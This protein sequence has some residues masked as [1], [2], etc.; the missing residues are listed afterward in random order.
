MERLAEGEVRLEVQRVGQA[1]WAIRVSDT[2][3][4]IPSHAQEV[5]FEKFR[6]IDGSTQRKHGGSGLGL[7]IVREL[8]LMMGGGVRVQSKPGE[9]STFTVLL[10]LT[11]AEK[12]SA[13]PE[14][15][16]VVA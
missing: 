4:G 16:K 9:G 12:T 1:D 5:I 11:A 13:Q 10:P 3:M 7:A 15:I 14:V 8:A 2:G 6:Q